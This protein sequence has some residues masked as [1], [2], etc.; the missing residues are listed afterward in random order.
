MHATPASNLHEK[1]GVFSPAKGVGRE[2]PRVVGCQLLLPLPPKG[3]LTQQVSA[4][5]AALK[6]PWAAKARDAPWAGKLPK[7]KLCSPCTLATF[8]GAIRT[9]TPTPTPSIVQTLP[10]PLSLPLPLPLLLSPA[11]ALTNIEYWDLGAGKS[12]VYNT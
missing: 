12:M 2:T 8:L 1:S 11:L 6:S 7:A 3:G 5:D 4:K 9:R 10:Q